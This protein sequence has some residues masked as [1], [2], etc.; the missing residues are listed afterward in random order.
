[1]VQLII[2][3]IISMCEFVNYD[4]LSLLNP[5]DTKLELPNDVIGIKNYN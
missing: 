3:G 5:T 4:I 2:D 1:M